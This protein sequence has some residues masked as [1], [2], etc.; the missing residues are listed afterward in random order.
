MQNE[1]IS[2]ISLCCVQQYSFIPKI[3]FYIIYI[4]F[5]Y[6]FKFSILEWG[7]G[8]LGYFLSVDDMNINDYKGD[9]ES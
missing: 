1:Y 3:I 9:V 5:I 7:W 4:L 6:L 8:F 2:L